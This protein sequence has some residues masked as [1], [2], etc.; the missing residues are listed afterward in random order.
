VLLVVAV[1][2]AAEAP[3]LLVA[4]MLTALLVALVVGDRLGVGH[5]R[6]WDAAV[7]PA[8]S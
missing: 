5:P 4:G 8:L 2:L 6:S 7:D 3:G 1:P